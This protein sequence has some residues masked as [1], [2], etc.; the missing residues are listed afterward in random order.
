MKD[1]YYFAYGS[2]MNLGADEVQVSAAEVG[3]KRPA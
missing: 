2:N 3:E 1:R